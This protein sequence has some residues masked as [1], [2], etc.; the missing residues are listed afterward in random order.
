MWAKK[1]LN[2]VSTLLHCTHQDYL[3][4]VVAD[5]EEFN[6]VFDILNRYETLNDA[7]VELIEQQ[8]KDL[9]MLE[10]ARTSMVKLTEVM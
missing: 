3:N 10:N 7:R 1:T 5:T 8:E 4:S 9:A 2:N 6:T